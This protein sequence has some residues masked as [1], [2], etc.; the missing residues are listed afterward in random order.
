M[1]V[2]KYKESKKADWR[3]LR[4]NSFALT[5]SRMRF[6]SLSHNLF[7]HVTIFEKSCAF[8]FILHFV[9][10]L[11]EVLLLPL[12][13]EFYREILFFQWKTMFPFT[14][15]TQSLYCCFVN[16]VNMFLVPK[17]F[18]SRQGARFPPKSAKFACLILYNSK[19]KSLK[20]NWKI[21]Y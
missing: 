12:D 14:T 20:R 6:S 5:E 3:N 11:L 9:L 18:E 19:T 15:W 17:L 10:N 21:T 13:I 4:K 1:F 16:A 2:R 8:W 7:S